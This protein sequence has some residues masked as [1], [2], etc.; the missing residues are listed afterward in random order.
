MPRIFVLIVRKEVTGAGVFKTF[1]I[2][3]RIKNNLEATVD[4]SGQ[5]TCTA[6]IHSLFHFFFLIIQVELE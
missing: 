3:P 5:K 1:R 2:Q 4:I 6:A